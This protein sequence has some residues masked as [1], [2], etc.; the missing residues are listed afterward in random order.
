[1]QRYFGTGIRAN[2]NCAG[3]IKHVK[4]CYAALQHDTR[5]QIATVQAPIKHVEPFRAVTQCGKG[6]QAHCNSAGAH[7]T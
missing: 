4:P 1:M 7:K 3:P 5:K 6:M 2:C